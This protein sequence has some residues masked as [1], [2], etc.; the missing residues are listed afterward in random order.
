MS[1][2]SAFLQRSCWA[3]TNAK[4]PVSAPSKSKVCEF[5]SLIGGQDKVLSTKGSA[6]ENNFLFISFLSEPPW[7]VGSCEG[8]YSG[9]SCL[10]ADWVIKLCCTQKQK[11]WQTASY[12]DK[13]FMKGGVFALKSCKP[14]SEASMSSLCFQV[15]LFRDNSQ[16]SLWNYAMWWLFLLCRFPLSRF[17]MHSQRNW[18]NSF[19]Q[20]WRKRL[21]LLWK[22]D[23]N[24]W[25]AEWFRVFIGQN[26]WPFHPV[27]DT[28]FRR[29]GSGVCTIT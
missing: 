19:G 14:F 6:L 12:H 5:E 15:V 10:V 13:W 1:G 8:W 28:K 7:Y 27:R 29:N 24:T 21:F 16:T 25:R 11:R 22:I 26:F 18:I 23:W 2:T 3:K 9:S 4:T 20:D 17:I